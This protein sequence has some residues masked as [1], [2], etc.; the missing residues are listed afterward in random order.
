VGSYPTTCS[1]ESDPNYDITNVPGTLQV[2]QAATAL[3]AA[4]VSVLGSLAS[5]SVTFR[6]TLTS[7]VTGNPIS[8][9]P[10]TFTWG[11]I[12]QCTTPTNATGVAS[13]RTSVLNL[14]GFLVSP[15]YTAHFAG[16]TDYSASSNSSTVTLGS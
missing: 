16:S 2:T 11:G 4:P 10:V 12:G 13:C 9:A 1:G 15:V 5:G 7:K 3:A 8:G 14:L 6:A